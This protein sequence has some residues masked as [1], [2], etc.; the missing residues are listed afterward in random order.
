MNIR[1]AEEFKFFRHEAD[2]NSH[3]FWQKTASFYKWHKQPQKSLEGSFTTAKWSWFAD[4][5]LNITESCLDRHAAITPD[6]VAIYFEPNAS[7]E[8]SRS[9][10]Y[11]QLLEDVCR[12]ANL[13][14][15]KNVHKGDVVCFYMP[16]GPELLTGLLAC[17]RIGAVHS[18]VFG[19]FSSTALQERILDCQAKIVVTSDVGL[20]GA[21]Q[22]QLLAVVREALTAVRCVS[23][24]IVYQR[25]KVELQLKAHEIAAKDYLQNMDATCEAV[26][27]QAEDP[28][29][30][31]YTSGSTGKPKGL[32]HTVGGYMVWVG[33]T[34]KNVF[35]YK[36]GDVFWCTADMGW[37]T[38]H[39]YVAY[40]PLLNGATQVIFEGLPN[41]PDA[42]RFWQIIE[43][44]NVTHFYTA[45]TAIRALEAE[46][47][48]LVRKHKMPSLKVL[49]SV[50]EPINEEA[51]QWYFDEVGKKRC[52]IVDTWWQTETGGIMISALAGVTPSVPAVATQPLPGVF[53]VLMS[54]DGKQ[55]TDPVSEGALCISR[56]WPG[57]AR[58]IY[59]D[60]A[61]YLQTYF[62]TYPGY[63]FTGD[64]AKRF[65]NGDF[66]IIGR[67]DDV[68]N[69]SGHRIGT[70]EVE[71]VV[72][73]HAC[74]VESAVI[75]AAHAIKGQ[76]IVAFVSCVS[77][78][79]QKELLVE[80]NELI[81]KRIGPIAKLEHLFVVDDL[82]KTR[83]GKIMRRVLRKAYEADRTTLGDTS[84]LVN[85]E[86][87]DVIFDLIAKYKTS[88]PEV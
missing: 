49:G 76:C 25:T 15:S 4:G 50:G 83:S 48:N 45:P 38:G 28:L 81:T 42:S 36:E 56:P 41:W 39:S 60:H 88:T 59:N 23:T 22:I 55:I 73:Q 63:Y 35:Q 77:H 54:P 46:D 85:P 82:P 30:I 87:V 68:V 58:T 5:Q 66:R 18:V 47:V 6:K 53:P 12:F 10:T 19:G 14:K 2:V 67:I 86:V 51:W 65:A 3:D 24:V 8:A 80:V 9:I 44:F 70:A 79:P 21:K 33:E 84:T 37:I 17:A 26:I 31:L 74:I 1:T 16:T 34:F 64:G 13:L 57:L 78:K 32:L 69:V 71:D 40:G 75:G 43:K 52:P 62:S 7:S 27:T 20:R 61:R 29:F 11:Q 72:N